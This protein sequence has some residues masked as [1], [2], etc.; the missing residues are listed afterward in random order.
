[1]A[2]TKTTE[3]L[4]E[5]STLISARADEKIAPFASY[6]IPRIPTSQ[7]YRAAW[8]HILANA[9]A[10]TSSKCKNLNPVLANHELI[11]KSIQR[12]NEALKTHPNK[13]DTFDKAVQANLL[14]DIYFLTGKAMRDISNGKEMRS[15]G[16][17]VLFPLIRSLHWASADEIGSRFKVD[18]Q[19]KHDS[20]HA[21]I[22]LQNS[23]RTGLGNHGFTLDNLKPEVTPNLIYLQN[24]DQTEALR[25]RFEGGL[26][27][28]WDPSTKSNV[29]LHTELWRSSRLKDNEDNTAHSPEIHKD[30]SGGELLLSNNH[31][32]IIKKNFGVA[33]YVMSIKREI[34]VR[35]HHLTTKPV[36]GYFYHSSYLAGNDIIC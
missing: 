10:S 21:D 1:M 6:H 17:C 18:A 32:V 13:A 27:K 12:Y 23:M 7:E 19:M 30:R 28:I 11:F 4:K 34:Y 14:S 26:L 16:D 15:L 3:E 22:Y 8:S 35:K 20:D 31:K 24:E 33:G 29:P 5:E 9:K 25:A 2:T 36:G